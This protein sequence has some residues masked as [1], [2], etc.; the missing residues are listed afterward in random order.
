MVPFGS[1]DAPVTGLKIT[2]SMDKSL[3]FNWLSVET[4]SSK[5]SLYN[6]ISMPNM[7]STWTKYDDGM[8][9]IYD[10]P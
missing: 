5:D 2:H 9:P 8:V 7:T 4:I 3:R 6:C 1:K 10:T